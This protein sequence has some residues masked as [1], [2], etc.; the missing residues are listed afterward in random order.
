[1]SAYDQTVGN[2]GGQSDDGGNVPALVEVHP[3]FEI[4]VDT[5]LGHRVSRPQKKL[6]M[7]R[8]SQK[9]ATMRLMMVHC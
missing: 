1:M 2:V 8:A 9:T 3:E 6:R 5:D 4:L 7:H